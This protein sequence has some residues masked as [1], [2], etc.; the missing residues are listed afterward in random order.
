[1]ISGNND[2]L[3]M[4]ADL[5]REQMCEEGAWKTLKS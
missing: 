2:R 3:Q 4:F 1:M 5:C